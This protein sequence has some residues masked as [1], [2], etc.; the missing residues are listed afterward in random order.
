MR[1]R[2]QRATWLRA[3]H[4]QTPRLLLLLLRLVLVVLLRGGLRAVLLVC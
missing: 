2:R 1:L 4:H 3:L